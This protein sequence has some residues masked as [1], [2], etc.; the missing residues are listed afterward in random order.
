MADDDYELIP[1]RELEALRAESEK[2]KRTPAAAQP[3][4]DGQSLLLS[5]NELN[6]NIRK[7]IDLFTNTEADLAKEYADHNPVEDLREIKKQNEQLASAMLALADIVKDMKDD[8][9][10]SRLSTANPPPLP[11]NMSM[12]SAPVQPIQQNYAPMPPQTQ[13]Q[14]AGQMQE[15]YPAP[16]PP[17]NIV[18]QDMI[19]P[20][21]SGL[22]PPPLDLQPAMKI[23]EKKRGFFF[24][25]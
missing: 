8:V 21:G 15:F 14:S 23:G 9:E 7:L 20:S 16:I 12:P 3:I 4:G 11:I 1:R 13:M 18:N 22:P 10:K 24:K 2:S 5:V 17:N 19:M 25:K 6:N